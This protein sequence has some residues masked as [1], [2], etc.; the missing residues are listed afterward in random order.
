MSGYPWDIS[1][2]SIFLKDIPGIS[3][4]YPICV[5]FKLRYP[6]LIFVASKTNIIGLGLLKIYQGYPLMPNLHHSPLQMVFVILLNIQI[7]H[8]SRTGQVQLFK[9]AVE[10]QCYTDIVLT[11]G[12]CDWPGAGSWTTVCQWVSSGK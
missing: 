4:T 1:G 10:Y 8:R 12:A 3:L 7:A 9:G 11:I 5:I 2:I 6:F